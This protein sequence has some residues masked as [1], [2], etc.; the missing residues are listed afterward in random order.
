M[1]IRFLFVGEGP[2]DDYLVTHLRRCCILAGADEAEDVTIP[3]AKLGD[4]IGRK[5]T[6]KLTFALALEPNVN[7]VFVHRDADAV[8][9]E[10]RHEEIR[11]AIHALS[12]ARPYVAV[13]PVQETE[14]WLLLDEMEIRRVADNPSGTVALDIPS[15]RRVKRI[16]NPKEHLDTVILT[17]SE[18]TGRRY[19]KAK[20]KV[21]QKCILMLQALDP[22]GPVREVPSWQRMFSDLE[23]AVEELSVTS[24]A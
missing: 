19:H 6:E 12:I 9:P 15:A 7:L 11:E 5:V 21:H 18:Q 20:S 14:A 22:E 1:Q 24:F 17:A 3:I 10:P 23:A 8:D 16:S 13:V 4:R 2:F